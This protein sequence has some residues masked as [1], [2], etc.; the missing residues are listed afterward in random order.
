[1]SW[2]VGRDSVQ[3]IGYLADLFFDSRKFHAERIFSKKFETYHSWMASRDLTSVFVSLDRSSYQSDGIFQFE[4]D[5]LENF[6]NT[7]AKVESFLLF[8]E[9]IDGLEIFKTIHEQVPN[10]KMKFVEAWSLIEKNCHW[11]FSVGQKVVREVY[12][13]RIRG[14]QYIGAGGATNHHLIGALFLS[15]RP[16]PS[17][18]VKL[19]ISFAH[20]IGHTVLMIMQQGD[21]II[22]EHPDVTVY[23]PV[24][25]C[26]R[27]LIMSLHAAVAA[28]YMVECAFD[29]SKSSDLN[30]EERDYCVAFI[31]EQIFHLKQTL[32]DMR[33][34]KFTEVGQKILHDLVRITKIHSSQCI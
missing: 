5:R 30:A 3:K 16:A 34:F 17:E 2:I 19:A 10:A 26:H 27:P 8:K 33:R 7:L 14:G 9:A 23:S 22:L 4:E 31:S 28:G 21:A 24:R 12:P 25:R 15:L 20:E 13:V 29:L 11:I 32:N 18:E 1:M 6:S